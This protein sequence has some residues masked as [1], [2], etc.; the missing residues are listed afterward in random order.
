[1]EKIAGFVSIVVTPFNYS[2]LCFTISYFSPSVPL[3]EDVYLMREGWFFLLSVWWFYLH[4]SCS[5]LAVL[6]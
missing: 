6:H 2:S 1:M 5:H 4:S 3:E